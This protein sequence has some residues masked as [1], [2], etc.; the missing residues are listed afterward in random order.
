[1]AGHGKPG[2]A[3]R[4]RALAQRRR[5]TLVH[6]IETMRER[7]R[8]RSSARKGIHADIAHISFLARSLRFRGRSKNDWGGYL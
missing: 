7:Q 1:M 8:S 3:K 6:R 4:Q 5:E 2:T